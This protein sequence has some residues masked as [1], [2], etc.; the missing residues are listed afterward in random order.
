[1]CKR[2]QLSDE[3]AAAIAN[4]VLVDVGKITEDDKTCVI[5]RSKLKRERETRRQEAQKE[6]QQNFRFV[7]AICFDDRKDAIQMV[8]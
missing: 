8:V 3:A 6:E 7:N 4:S 5:D 1:M 2:Y